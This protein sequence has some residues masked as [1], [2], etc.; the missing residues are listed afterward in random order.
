MGHEVRGRI[1]REICD[2]PARHLSRVAYF[3][4]VYY[5]KFYTGRLL[6]KVQPLTHL[7]TILSEKVLPPYTLFYWKEYPF[8]IPT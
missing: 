1:A 6:P 3:S 5:T 2:S 8:H 4:Q 7:R